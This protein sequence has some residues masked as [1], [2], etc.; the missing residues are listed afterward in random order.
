M[1]TLSL[2]TAMAGRLHAALAHRTQEIASS[3]GRLSSGD[4]LQHAGDDVASLSIATKLSVRVASL[5]SARVNAE[6]ASSLLQVMDGGLQ[7]IHS[8][9][10]RMMALS[11]QSASGALSAAERGFLN[12][13]FGN[14]KDE[15]DRIAAETNFN[16]VNLL[17]ANTVDE[18][19]RGLSFD[20]EDAS[21]ASAY[22]YFFNRPTNNQTFRVQNVLF[23]FRTNPT[24]GNAT[25]IRIGAT[26]AE[27]VQNIATTL[28]AYPNLALQE[29][30]YEPIAGQGLLKITSKSRGEG[31]RYFTIDEQGS[32]SR[33]RF[34]VSGADL[35]Y[36]GGDGR[37]ALH[38]DDSTGLGHESS[39]GIG[40]TGGLLANQVQTSGQ[41][42][43]SMA[44]LTGGIGNNQRIRIDN[45]I[46][47]LNTFRFRTNPVVGNTFHIEIGADNKESLRNAVKVLTEWVDVTPT[48]RTYAHEQLEFERDGLNLIIR[49]KN[50]GNG[51][52]FRENLMAVAETLGG[53]TLSGAV[54]SGGAESGISAGAVH[55]KDFVGKIQGFTADYI[56]DNQV[57]L[58]VTV[59]EHE[60]AGTFATNPTAQT[61][62]RIESEEG[63][64]FDL[65]LA[66]G[67]MGVYDQDGADA[68][69]AAMEQSFAGVTFYQERTVTGYYPY[70]TE[71]QGS[72]LS[73]RREDFSEPMQ[74]DDFS[75]TGGSDLNAGGNASAIFSITING[76]KFTS[77]KTIER[78]VEAY[79]EIVMY[80]EDD[81]NRTVT[82]HN[83]GSQIDTMTDSQAEA[84]EAM[85]KTVLPKG[86]ILGVVESDAEVSFQVGAKTSNNLAFD[87]AQVRLSALFGD[88]DPNIATVE[89]AEA[90]Q[91]TVRDAMDLI[92]MK[93]AEVGAQQSRTGY[94][95]DYIDQAST[96]QRA[97]HARLADTDIAEE[98]TNY[99]TE[100]VLQQST[101][102]LIAQT[103]RLQREFVSGVYDPQL[104]AAESA[105]AI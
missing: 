7:Q 2:N 10:D 82:F 95:L 11:V 55:N 45:G 96:A 63:G 79:A 77:T 80:S 25:H 26:V 57:R 54:V 17:D 76:E 51:A 86:D 62:V 5:K 36:T 34:L 99:A 71:L 70:Q 100:T 49:N 66:A 92:V 28:N 101:L 12:Q 21:E 9:L 58:K 1:Q 47:G 84:F 39:I 15:V 81:A 98:T 13:E 85:M 23:R 48:I 97:A 61:R 90:A 50:V 38:A 102:A 27:T 41:V 46:N 94:A 88:E 18:V 60:Y 93:R 33:T 32:S 56:S 3:T 83:G 75:V 16:G 19:L 14:L 37:W 68:Y 105:S 87:L 4:R 53:G 64:Y 6:Q 40:S 35:V 29:V 72:S 67:G 20:T 69:A 74:I 30:D 31:A 73:I 104:Q 42:V 59:G 8:A 24:P 44:A 43:L 103:N 22:L 89:A 65:D 78:G 91:E 52:D